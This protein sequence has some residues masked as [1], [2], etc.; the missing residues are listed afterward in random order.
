[1]NNQNIIALFDN[2]MA[3]HINKINKKQKKDRDPREWI[4]PPVVLARDRAIVD[5]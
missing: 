3:T 2:K 5:R 1:M 4:G